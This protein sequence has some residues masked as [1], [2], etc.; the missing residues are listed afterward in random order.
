[1]INKLATEHMSLI[2]FITGNN[3]IRAINITPSHGYQ[4]S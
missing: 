3:L 1:M 4:Q 2:L